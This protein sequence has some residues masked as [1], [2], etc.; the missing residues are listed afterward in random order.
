MSSRKNDQATLCGTKKRTTEILAL[1]HTDVCGLFD[2]QTRGGYVY[3]IIFINDY[4]WY[5]FMYLMHQKS[6]VFEKFIEFRYKVEK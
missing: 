3:F 6:E 4:S 5:R 1:V 2:V